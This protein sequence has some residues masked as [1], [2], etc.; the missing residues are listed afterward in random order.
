MT[1][2]TNS[3]SLNTELIEAAQKGDFQA[4][5]HWIEAGADP[6]VDN[7]AAYVLA[8]ANNHVDIVDFLYPLVDEPVRILA[9]EI[10]TY[11]DNTEMIDYLYTYNHAKLAEQR[12]Q[13]HLG[14]ATLLK[15]RMNKDTNQTNISNI[16]RKIFNA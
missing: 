6:L 1:T 5:Q 14:A 2:Q 16:K 8:V 15:N 4:V 10:A 12:L 11:N 9:L 3:F 13:S 7:G